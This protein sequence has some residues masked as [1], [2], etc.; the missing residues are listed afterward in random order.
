MLDFINNLIELLGNSL[1]L[2]FNLLIYLINLF[3][4]LLSGLINFLVN[5]LPNSPFLNL[6][7]FEGIEQY[8]GYFNWLI[9]VD[10]ILGITLSWAGCIAFYKGYSIIMIYFNII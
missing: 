4:W 10:W 2:I 7:I 6:N 5:L 9:P 8:L 3:V 1:L